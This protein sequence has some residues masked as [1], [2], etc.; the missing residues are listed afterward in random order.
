MNRIYLDY[1]AATPV[2]SRVTEAMLPY[3]ADLSANPSAL[4]KEGVTARHAV[5]NARKQIA[6]QLKVQPDEI[7]FTSSATESANL[8]ILGVVH[9]WKKEHPEQT[10][11]VIIS[12]IEH[13]A[14]FGPARVLEGT[15]VRLSIL[16]VD[17]HGVVKLD[18]LKELITTDTVVVAVMLANNEIG[19]IEPIAEVSKIVRKWKKE[20]RGVIRSER[21]LGDDCYPLLY[22]DASQ[23]P[24]YL[25]CTPLSLGVDMMTL[26]SAKIYGPKGGGLLFRTRNTKLDSI[27]FGGGQEQGL[28]PGTE[29]V[30]VLVGF[31]VALLRTSEL[32]DHETERLSLVR[33]ATILLLQK[34]FPNITINGS[35]EHR[36][37]NNINFSFPEID[38][39][40]LALALDARGFA[41][42]TKSACSETEAEVSH[43]L[44]ALKQDESD[45]RPV[46]GIRISMG[47]GTQM[48]DM[49][50]F[51]ATLS[52][53]MET[54]MVTI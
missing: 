50:K 42:A 36:L 37:A 41:V 46:S 21:P 43:V 40:F 35:L 11:H 5:E 22:T 13:E 7:I 24:N 20:V 14:V 39:E 29:N 6:T 17:E 53:I 44:L 8:A 54:M 31:A 47:R 52:D 16:P 9:A 38:H 12:A 18:V 2:D 10:P 15:G 27:L 32:R 4:H 45:T 3:F 26:S 25:D 30:P 48:E 28:R 23:A 19:T 1:A 33:D 34:Q 51:V 49:D